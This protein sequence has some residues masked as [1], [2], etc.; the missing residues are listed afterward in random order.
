MGHHFRD[1]VAGSDFEPFVALITEVGSPVDFTG[2]TCTFYM[3]LKSDPLTV[4]ID[5]QACEVP[6][7]NGR[8]IYLPTAAEIGTP[9]AYWCRYTAV[10]PSGKTFKTPM[11]GVDITAPT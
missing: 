7:A 2:G 6:T 9:G 3:S 5:E 11:I 8:L 4:P 1:R 10:L